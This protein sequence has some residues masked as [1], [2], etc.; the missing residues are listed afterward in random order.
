[1]KQ[2]TTA[3]GKLK[4]DRY[5]KTTDVNLQAWDSADSYIL[6]HLHQRGELGRV[7]VINDTFGTLTTALHATD[8]TLWSDSKLAEIAVEVNYGH[9][10]LPLHYTFVP[11]TEKPIGKFDTI[12]IKIP[13]NNRYF[14]DILSQIPALMNSTSQLVCGAMVKF[15]TKRWPQMVEERLGHSQCSLTWKKSRLILSDATQIPTTQKP[16]IKAHY[17]TDKP[18]EMT[19]HKLSNVYNQGYL[20]IGTR[21]LMRELKPFTGVEHIADLGCGSGELGLMAL[22]LNPQAQVEFIDE[23]YQA[24][25]SAKENVAANL[26]ADLARCQFTCN[27]GM[28][29]KQRNHYGAILC[30]PPFHQQHTIGDHIAWGMM[31]QARKALKQN[32]EFWLVGNRHLNYHVKMQRL[33]ANCIQVGGNNKFV[34]LKSVKSNKPVNT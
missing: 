1:M 33:F 4:L 29:N 28:T 24:V 2:L 13:Q 9:N 10:L 25:A 32:G 30:N 21:V 20:D 12:V 19:I 5:P 3:F 22:K 17:E 7:L 26:P 18:L 14:D 15:W 16:V 6:Q 34:V 8:V 11:S 27:D 31:Q 23:S